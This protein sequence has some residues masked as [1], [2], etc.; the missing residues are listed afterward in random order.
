MKLVT[1]LG[2]FLVLDVAFTR[3]LLVEL[4]TESA[5]NDGSSNGYKTL[6]VLTR[7]TRGN[8]KLKLGV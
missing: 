5:P 6:K 4:E 7:G 3:Y 1:L 2:S 8:D